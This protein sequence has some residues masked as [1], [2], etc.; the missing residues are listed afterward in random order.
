MFENARFSE[1]IGGGG[2]PINVV[3]KGDPSKPAILFIHGFRQ[4]YLSWT[5]QFE[6]RLAQEYHLVAFDL[7]GHGNSGSPWRIDAYDNS[8]PWADDVE[9]V[10]KATGIKKPLIVGWSFGGNVAMDFVR[11]YPAEHVAGL[12]L[13]GTAAGMIAQP[14]P[15]G[16][17]PPRPTLSSDLE[18]NI[19]AVDASTKLLFSE[20]VDPALVKKFTAAAMRVSPFVDRAIAARDAG[21]NLDLLPNFPAPITVIFGGNDPIF[22][23]ETAEKLKALIPHANIIQFPN[24][25]HALFL[26]DPERFN[27]V[28]ENLRCR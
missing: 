1:V 14:R 28:L 21:T 3:E 10:I 20:N 17:T 6:S 11:N 18:A 13:V 5:A 22:R 26:D 24:A 8:R 2:V 16:N 12:V 9:R 7:R 25:G 27:A 15:P 4:S 23:P 19:R